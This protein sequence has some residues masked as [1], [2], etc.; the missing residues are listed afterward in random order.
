[1]KRRFKMLS[2]VAVASLTLLVALPV[3]AASKPYINPEAIQADI[4]TGALMSHLV[5]LDNIAT[6]NNGNRAFGLPGYTASVD[7]IWER[8]SNI[9]GTR[10]WK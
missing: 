1:M 4:T 7:Y 6:A 2:P 9:P 3:L 8:V 5:A 10:A